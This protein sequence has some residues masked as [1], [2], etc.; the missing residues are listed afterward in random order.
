MSNGG[1]TPAQI[2]QVQQ[3]LQN[4]QSFNDYVYNQGQSK[5]LN[6]YLLL[7]EQDNSDPGLTIGLNILEGA[8]WAV[9]SEF[10][11]VGN[12]VASFM[13]GMVSW[14]ATNTPPNLNTTFA[15]LLTRFQATSLAVDQ[16]LAQYYQDVAGNWQT[17][18]TY[19]GVTTTLADLSTVTFPAENNPQF[20]TM[21]KASLFALDQ[22]IWTTVM[23]ADF[24]IT[25]WLLS[26][27]PLILTGWGQNNP[28]VGWDEMF[29]ARNPAY[30]NTWSWHNSSG[31]GDTSGWQI[32]QY[33][34]GTGAGLTDGS[35]A[36]DACAYLFIDSADGVTINA[37]G[38]FPRATV[39]N[40][41]GIQTTPQPVAAGG[42]GAVAEKLSL[43]YLRA[44]KSGQTLGLLIQR[45]GR[46]AVQQRVIEKAQNDSVFATDLAFRPRQTLEEFLGV[47]IPETVSVSVIVETPNTFALVVPMAGQEE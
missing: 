40:N 3:N 16:Q 11:P 41:L 2:Q 45:E 32:T 37:N 1:P 5:V 46:E 22:Q 4:M 13:S 21:A 29:I 18:F 38:L 6:A 14:W 15:S 39:F 25:L 30:Y 19:N 9:G 7:S 34:I 35:M 27:G 26:S 33:N 44:M 47:K 36:A 12:F 8:F 24:V 17:Q 10:G 31:C 20:E 23:R 42:G 28:P 43:S